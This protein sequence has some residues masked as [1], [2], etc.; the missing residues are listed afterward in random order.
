MIQPNI[1]SNSFLYIYRTQV[2]YVQEVVTLQKKYLIYLHQTHRFL[3]ITI[4]QVEY[5]SYTEQNNFRTHEL[6]WIKQF[7]SI[8]QVGS[9]LSRH[10]V[11]SGTYVYQF[12]FMFHADQFEL[13]K[14]PIKNI[15]FHAL[16]PD[17]RINNIN[18]CSDQPGLGLVVFTGI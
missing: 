6:D 18:T 12:A 13:K 14:L 16:Q 8:F 2:L 1:F 3:T 5:Y 4:F 7:D 17:L 11:T 10:T 9:L 15:T